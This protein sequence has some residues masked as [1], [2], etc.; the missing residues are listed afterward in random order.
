MNTFFKLL[1]K[2]SRFFY[3]ILVICLFFFM[4]K[5]I[6][7]KQELFSLQ[8]QFPHSTDSNNIYFQIQLCEET[9]DNEPLCL[10]W[11]KEQDNFI[12]TTKKCVTG[13]VNQH[14]LYNKDNKHIYIKFQS[15]NYCLHSD[16]SK[17][18][19][20][21]YGRALK[22]DKCE[23]DK[24]VQKWTAV[25]L[26]NSHQNKQSRDNCFILRDGSG[27]YRYLDGFVDSNNNKNEIAHM[28]I[29]SRFTRENKNQIWKVV[30]VPTQSR[31]EESTTNEENTETPDTGG[32]ETDPKTTHH[33]HEI[34][35]DKRTIKDNNNNPQYWII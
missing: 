6:L 27:Q 32:N 4:I 12:V 13:N 33:H 3:L 28:W 11:E 22:L 9:K 31:T 26:K 20:G 7:N 34:D 29:R 10:G 14:W 23:P 8:D 17:K 30:K 5:Q 16:I 18:T 24:K 2:N 15:S 1:K 19:F 21:N 35:C 25:K